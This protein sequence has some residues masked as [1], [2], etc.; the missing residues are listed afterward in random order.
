MLLFVVK[1]EKLSSRIGLVRRNDWY[2]LQ[3]SRPVQPTSWICSFES[4]GES[5]RSE[6]TLEMLSSSM[7]R[8]KASIRFRK[9]V[10]SYLSRRAQLRSLARGI[11]SSF[12]VGLCFFTCSVCDSIAISLKKSLSSVTA[13]GTVCISGAT[14]STNARPGSQPCHNTFLRTIR[15]RRAL[16]N[17]A[18]K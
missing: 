3:F 4:I 15:Q 5:R 14:S 1:N 7:Y 12:L 8:R 11:V 6:F 16:A 9:E 13:E 2:R 17:L 18:S 10:L